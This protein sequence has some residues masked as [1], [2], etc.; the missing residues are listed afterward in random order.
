MRQMNDRAK[1]VSHSLLADSGR[2]FC[3]ILGVLILLGTVDLAWAMS[4]R[5]GGKFGYI[6]RTGKVVIETK[7]DGARDFSEGLAAVK[8]KGN[9]ER[10]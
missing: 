4:V 2:C 9:S 3:I 6:D 5:I 8:I 1:Q 7:F 10:F